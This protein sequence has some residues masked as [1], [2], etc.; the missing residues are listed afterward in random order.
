MSNAP[1][2][3]AGFVSS[4]LEKYK[5][6]QSESPIVQAVVAATSDGRIDESKLVKDLRALTLPSIKESGT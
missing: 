2:D 5:A 1:K 6:G 4:W 3:D